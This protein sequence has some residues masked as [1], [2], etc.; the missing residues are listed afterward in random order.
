MAWALPVIVVVASI[1]L[2][3]ARS[4]R[5]TAKRHA[6][7]E[8]KDAEEAM[9]ELVSPDARNHDTWDL[10]LAWPIDDPYLESLRRRCLAIVQDCAPKHAR[11]ESS[12]EVKAAVMALLEELRNRE[13]L[14]SRP[15]STPIGR[16]AGGSAE[17]PG[18]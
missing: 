6:R 17:Q 3:F 13:Q 11:A 8:P 18:T 2:F 7:F 10:L 1:G 4:N 5:L 14:I 9:V 15:D 12:E 16:G